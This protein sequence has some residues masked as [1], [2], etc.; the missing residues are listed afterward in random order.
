MLVVLLRVVI[1][2]PLMSAY[3]PPTQPEKAIDKTM[4]HVQSAVDLYF[5]ST[6]FFHKLH[7]ES[8]YPENN[9]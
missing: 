5:S 6:H 9:Y 1:T 4:V 8:V 2:V 3:L 7:L